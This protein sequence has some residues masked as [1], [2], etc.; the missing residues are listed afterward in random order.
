MLTLQNWIYALLITAVPVEDGVKSTQWWG[1]DSWETSENPNSKEAVVKAIEARKAR[2]LEIAD[3][4]AEVVFDPK[5]PSLFN[6]DKG[7]FQTAALMVSIDAEES[8]LHKHVDLGIGSKA[9]GDAGRSWCLG[10]VMLGYDKK[11]NDSAYGIKLSDLYYDYVP[12]KDGWSG[13]D[14]V[15]DRSKCFRTQLHIM[16]KSLKD[17]SHLKSEVRLAGYVAGRCDIGW[18]S[19]KKRWDGGLELFKK[20]PPPNELVLEIN[21]DKK[22]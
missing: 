1:K 14:L 3:S 13:L 8:M 18:K 6:G 2:Y 7:R 15:K 4:L 17:C 19:A 22:S 10:Q 9:K 16:R 12:V 21:K 11:L 5:E 20:V